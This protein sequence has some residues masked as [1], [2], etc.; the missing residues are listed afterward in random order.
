MNSVRISFSKLCNMSIQNNF[1]ESEFI[2]LYNGI[3]E[4]LVIS[5]SKTVKMQPFIAKACLKSN[6]STGVW[7]PVYE[8]FYNRNKKVIEALDIIFTSFHKHGIKKV[9]LSENFG[10]LL[11]SDSDFA[12]FASG[13]VDCCADCSEYKKICTVFEELKFSRKEKY[14]NKLLISSEFSNDRILPKNFTISIDL[15]PLS[16]LS[17]PC[18]VQTDTFLNWNKMRQYGSTSIILPPIDALMYICLLHISLHSF[19]REPAI[20]L[21]R[22]IVNAAMKIRIDDWASIL[23]WAKRDKVCRR[24]SVAA[25]ISSIIGN[26]KIPTEITSFCS[27]KILDLVF[28]S[29]NDILKDEPNRLNVLRIETLCNDNSELNGMKEIL[30]PDSDWMIEV[31]G[32]NNVITK[33]KHVFDI[34]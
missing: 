4:K 22:D 20:R 3:G 23:K 17:M 2:S 5:M 10:A 31:Y 24:I 27:K 14:S 15:Y 19:C 32:K 28:D 9:F 8:N 21:Y 34:L 12:L 29:D 11:S 1:V 26:V 13:D 33:M 6:I 16:R 7:K 18:F 25:Y 30:Y